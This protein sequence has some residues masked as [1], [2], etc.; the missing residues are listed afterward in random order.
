MKPELKAFVLLTIF[1]LLV[2]ALLAVYFN[3]WWIALFGLLLSVGYHEDKD[4]KDD[5]KE[6]ADHH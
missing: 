6:D 1:A 5:N 2:F 3:H 4:G